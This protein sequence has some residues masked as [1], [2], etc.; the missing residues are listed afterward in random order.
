MDDDDDDNDVIYLISSEKCLH[1]AYFLIRKGLLLLL[2]DV[3][4]KNKTG[5]NYISR[6]FCY[7]AQFLT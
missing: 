5:M 6:C 7:S 2:C 4:S 1:V 3:N